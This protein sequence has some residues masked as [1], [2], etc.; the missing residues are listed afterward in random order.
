MDVITG[1]ECLIHLEFLLEF[2]AAWEK[3]PARLTPI[4]YRWCSVISEAAGTLGQREISTPSESP[5]PLDDD[6]RDQRQRMQHVRLRLRRMYRERRTLIRRERRQDLLLTSPNTEKEFTEAGPGCDPVRL[7]D[8]SDRS[9]G[10]YLLT[11]DYADILFVILEIGFRLAPPFGYPT[12]HMNHRPHHDW[13]FETALSSDDDE[14]VAD[15]TCAWMAGGETTPPGS[16]VRFAAKRIKKGRPFS[17]RLRREIKR[18]VARTWRHELGVSPLETVQLL[19]HLNLCMDD[20]GE[21]PRETW[22]EALVDA[23]CSPTGLE[24]LSPHYWRVLDELGGASGMGVGFGFYGKDFEYFDAVTKS[25]EE[26]ED[27]EKLEVWML[28]K[29]GS[30][31]LSESAEDAGR[32]TLKLLLRRPSALLRFTES[33]R[34]LGTSIKHC[35]ELQRICDRVRGEQP[36]Q[37]SPPYV[38]VRSTQHIINIVLMSPLFV[39]VGRFTPCPGHSF[40]FLSWETTLSESVQ[41]VYRGLHVDI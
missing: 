40:P 23:I 26:A 36:P 15:A 6:D 3:R 5:R 7:G 4:A 41:C 32:A 30:L 17:P 1:G 38:P 21:R 10:R 14:V 27:W 25:F 18:V 34:V 12:L 35:A 33:I 24:N 22:A 20:M 19:N 8:T 2:L 16:F 9:R 11:A 39:T 29:W 28:I 13:L 31:Q 37:E